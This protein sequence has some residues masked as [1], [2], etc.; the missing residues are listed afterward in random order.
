MNKLSKYGHSTQQE[1]VNNSI[2]NEWSG[3]FE[4]KVNNPKSKISQNRENIERFSQEFFG[5]D[6][7]NSLNTNMNNGGYID[8]EQK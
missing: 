6:S 1:M 5:N 2:I 8:Y 3:L 4:I 7:N